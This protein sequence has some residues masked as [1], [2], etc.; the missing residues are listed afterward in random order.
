MKFTAEAKRI[1]V[2]SRSEGQYQGGVE[3]VVETVVVTVAGGRNQLMPLKFEPT[4]EEALDLIA[5]VADA[6]GE[7]GYDVVTTAEPA[8]S[9][10]K[11]RGRK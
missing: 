10:G 11:R 5:K 4:V 1:E 8:Q 7:L 9:T 2:M 6:L 3:S